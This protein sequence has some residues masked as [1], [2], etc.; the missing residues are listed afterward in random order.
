[1]GDTY[2]PVIN[3]PAVPHPDGIR[4][5]PP[6]S[7]AF[8]V[9]NYVDLI[10]MILGECTG[11]TPLEQI[12]DAVCRQLPDADV[13]VVTAVLGHLRRVGVLADIR[14]AWASFHQLT[15][16]PVRYGGRPWEPGKDCLTTRSRQA[17]EN[18][19]TFKPE[20]LDPDQ[21]RAILV[22]TWRAAVNTGP[23]AAGLSLLKICVIAVT[24]Q[25]CLGRGCYEYDP[26]DRRLFR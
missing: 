2:Y 22:G 20:G 4:F 12:K 11:H 25:A 10:W 13:D 16:Q 15:C 1:M 17:G 6:R 18:T 24:D 7:R 14:D 3:A 9:S 8:V 5:L 23:S 19:C 21:L 26:G